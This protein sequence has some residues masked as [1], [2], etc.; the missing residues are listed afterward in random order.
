MLNG[1]DAVMKMS[2]INLFTL[3]SVANSIFMHKPKMWGF[4]LSLQIYV[5][6]TV[7][8]LNNI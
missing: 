6:R 8:N 5:S 3:H 4:V 2:V 7:S 1:C